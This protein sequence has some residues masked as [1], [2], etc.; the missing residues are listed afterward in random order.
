[1]IDPDKYS[2]GVM[3]WHKNKKMD[4][5]M[6]FRACYNQ[7]VHADYY[8]KNLLLP[9]PG[10]TYLDIITRSNI[11]YVI[12]MVKNSGHLGLQKRNNVNGETS[13]PNK[14]VKPLFTAGQKTKRTFGV[15]TL[16]KMGIKYYNNAKKKWQEAYTKIDPQYMILWQY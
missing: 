16:N 10:Y 12:S 4:E 1:M 7:N 11:A 15:T 5:L 3:H 13:R 2:K 14:L 8:F 6:Q 9:N